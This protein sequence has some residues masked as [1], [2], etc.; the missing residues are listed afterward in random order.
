[1]KEV[2]PLIMPFIIPVLIFVSGIAITWVLLRFK[3]QRHYERAQ[4]ELELI[5]ATIAERLA[6][7]EQ[8]IEELKDSL[9][10]RLTENSHLSNDL[11]FQYEKRAA[12]EEKNSRIPDLERTLKTKEEQ[13]SE[14]QRENSGLLAGLSEI[15][16]KL[17]DERRASDE[18]L[19]LLNEAQTQLSDAFRVLSSDALR[20]NNQ[21]F[22]ELAKTTLEKFQESA[23]GDLQMRQHAIGELV[24]PLKDSL[25]KVDAN[26][27]AIETARTSAYASLYEQVKLLS[28]MQ[29]QLQRETS[30][31]VQA[32]RAP[33]VRG[34]WGEIQLKRVVEVAGMIQYC[35]FIQQQSVSTESGRLRPDMIIKLPNRKNV[36][37]DSK[38]PLQGYLEALEAKDEPT[39][40]VKLQEHARQ[41]R[42]HLSQLSSKAYWEQFSPAPE[43]AVLFL[44]G[45]TFFS[46]A[47]EQDPGL[48]EFGVE[49]RVILATPTTLIALLRAIAYGWRQE[50]IAEN[51]QAIS[52]LGRVLYDRI[53]GFVGH[54]AEIKKGLDRAVYAYN[55]ALGSMEG[56]VLVAARRF[57][58]LGAASGNDIE[59]LAPIDK[60]TRNPSTAIP[61]ESPGC[62]GEMSTFESG[63]KDLLTSAPRSTVK[64]GER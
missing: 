20:S 53:R 17:E 14:L 58:E 23:R 57:K 47:L 64:N 52:E 63:G 18:K 21:S 6:A 3:V 55:K 50:Q 5:Q 54:F 33:M 46:A 12:A 59:T 34:R 30:N 45:E 38:A 7:K 27:R 1:M 11:K 31:L 13:I 25:E 39:R 16:A 36:V 44:P 40:L 8:K 48:I 60:I 49:R 2:L 43:F 62:S 56:R 10:K 29:D 26:I 15:T 42:S 35:D 22:L 28:N 4:V 32:L 41:I 9:G 19:A 61:L 37:V 51:A 24:G